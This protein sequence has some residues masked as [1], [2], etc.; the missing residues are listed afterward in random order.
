MTN[1]VIN[2]GETRMKEGKKCKK[3]SKRKQKQQKKKIV[4]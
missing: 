1:E 4:I 3:Q 2:G